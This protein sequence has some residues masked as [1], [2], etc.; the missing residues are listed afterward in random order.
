MSARREERHLIKDTADDIKAMLDAGGD[1]TDWARIRAMSQEEV[2]RLADENDGPLP[3][4][5][6]AT[7]V[8]GFPEPKT[9]VHIRLAAKVV[10]WFKARRGRAISHG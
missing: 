8:M 9:D 1:M 5:W 6:E 10:R 2:E 3:E 4:G 7:I